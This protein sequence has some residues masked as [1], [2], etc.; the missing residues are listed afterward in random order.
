MRIL[1][2]VLLLSL[3]S[4]FISRATTNSQLS[5]AKFAELHPGT[6]TA[7]EVVE[8]LGAPAEVVQLGTRSA[9]RYEFNT[10]K[11]EGFTILIF[12]ALNEDLRADRAWLFFDA[13]DVLTHMG[14]SFEAVGARYAMPWEPLHGG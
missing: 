12:S 7:R 8:L 2:A 10:L 4:C 1:A 3:S 13:K 11:R 5:R 6:T 9:Y 14:T